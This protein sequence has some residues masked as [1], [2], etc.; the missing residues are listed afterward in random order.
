MVKCFS[1][2]KG[3]YTSIFISILFL[4]FF[5][6]S[7]EFQDNCQEN[8][9]GYLD[10]V[11]FKEETRAD[12]A[13]DGSGSFTEGDKVGLYIQGDKGLSYRELTY[14]GGQWMPRLKRSDFGEGPISLSAHYPATGEQQNPETYQLNMALDQTGDGFNSS[15]LLFSKTVIGLG[16]YKADMNFGHA[17]HRIRVFLSGSVT[18]PEVKVRS[19][20][21]G[22]FNLLTGEVEVSGTDF[23]WITPFKDAEGNFS[24]VIIP[25]SALPYRDN[26]GLL[27]IVAEG[28]TAYFNAPEKTE[29]NNDLTFFK[30]GKQISINLTLKP[31]NP[32]LAGKSL[33]VYGLNVP[34]FP[35]KENLPTYKLGQK[36]GLPQGQWIRYDN[37]YYEEQYLTWAEGC[38]WYD[39]NK[40]HENY[41]DDS[42]MCWAA[43]ASNV[44]SWWMYLNKEYLAAYDKDYGSS[45]TT[46][47]GTFKRPSYDFKPLYP[48]GVGD[49]DGSLPE[50]DYVTV[51][52][53]EVFQFFKDHFPNFGNDDPK[54]V[55]WFFTG[56]YLGGDIN[57]FKGFLSEVFTRNNALTARSPHNPDRGQFNAFVT[58]ALLNKRAIGLNVF[59]V[60]GPKTG[61]HAMTAWGVEY[62]EA[63]D[64]AYIYYCDNNF[65]EQDPNGAVLIRQQVVYAVD[66]YGKECTYLQQLKPEDPDTR[67]GKFLITSVFSADLGRDIWKKKYPYVVVEK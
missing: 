24:A 34:D 45:V 51:N 26:D 63:G 58:D 7:S 31:G 18:S 14:S 19:L 30:S 41:E 10:I 17:L 37:R 33:W 59:D 40:S 21:Q 65:A 28:K 36:Y 61:N 5:S 44:V 52:R 1:V 42:Q 43:S 57:G 49:W 20:T 27:Q 50:P 15:D 32:E 48:N 35:G 55:E 2:F 16:V 9:D 22:N 23:K 6:C 12:L 64:I 62:D 38:G 67:V 39:C 66:S 54:G 29:E 13:S 60:A 25:Q 56:A 4:S 53:S 47:S 3:I 46:G 8:D 11:F